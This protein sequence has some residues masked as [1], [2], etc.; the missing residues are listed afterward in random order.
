MK[1]V[2]FSENVHQDVSLNRSNGVQ[3]DNLRS[4]NNGC[5]AQ[6]VQLSQ[7]ILISLSQIFMQQ[8]ERA[9]W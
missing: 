3:W 4:N 8:T 6:F 9:L 1:I 2:S 5:S 7:I